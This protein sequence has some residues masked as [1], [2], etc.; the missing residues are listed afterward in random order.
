[1]NLVGESVR[2]ERRDWLR[3][4]EQVWMTLGENYKRLS[5]Q[6]TRVSYAC[7]DMAVKVSWRAL[8]YPASA[9]RTLFSGRFVINL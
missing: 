1:M 5:Q 4:A 9:S 2:P 3:T 6:M 8:G 7:Q